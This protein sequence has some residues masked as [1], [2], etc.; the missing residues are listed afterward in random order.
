MRALLESQ[1]AK[2]EQIVI[3]DIKDSTFF[4]KLIIRS[5]GEVQEIDAR[6]S[7]GIALALRMQAPI[8]V[9]DKIALEESVPDKKAEVQDTQK[10][11]KFIDELKPSDFVE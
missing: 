9:T 7:D 8:F 5:N 1:H 10:F 4:A 2:L 6:P 3:H 11:K